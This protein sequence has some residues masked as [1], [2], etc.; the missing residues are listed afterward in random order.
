M[1]YI[2]DTNICIYIIKKKPTQV[3]EKFKDLPL[4]SVGIS[5]I[6]LAELAY[7]V[8]KSVQSKKNQIALNQF[9][10]PL[11]ILEFDTNVAIEYGKIRAELEKAGT[12]IGPLDM[13]IASHVK[14]LDL[15]IVTNNEK[16]FKRVAGL[17]VENWTR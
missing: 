5:S 9:L 8:N 13:L 10:I 12:P 11:D 4:G 6:T 3:F 7:G 15:T 16:E 2:L 14:S 1:K 17:K